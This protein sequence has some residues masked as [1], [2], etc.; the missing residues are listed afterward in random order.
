MGRGPFIKQVTCNSTMSHSRDHCQ[1]IVKDNLKYLLI[2]SYQ[3]A[4]QNTGYKISRG[5]QFALELYDHHVLLW[6]WLLDSR[7]LN[8]RPSY[9]FFSFFKGLYVMYFLLYNFFNFIYIPL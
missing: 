1:D 7:Q 6:G 5:A 2:L 8:W 3:E 9:G 4:L